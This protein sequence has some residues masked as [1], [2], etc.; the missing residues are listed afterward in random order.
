MAVYRRNQKYNIE[1]QRD[2]LNRLFPLYKNEEDKLIIMIDVDNNN[3]R[4]GE[5]DKLRTMSR[6][7]ALELQ[8]DFDFDNIKI[9]NYP[10]R[11]PDL[12]I[13]PMDNPHATG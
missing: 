12:K 6:V 9:Y 7:A 3:S 4:F 13:A 11:H 1:M 8:N 2:I 5:T 10:T